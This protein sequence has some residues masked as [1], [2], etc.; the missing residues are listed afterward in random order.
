MVLKC[1]KCGCQLRLKEVGDML[2]FGVELMASCGACG[3]SVRAS[4][5][6]DEIAL[7]AMLIEIKPQPVQ[8][9]N[10]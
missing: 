4:G 5:K 9:A 8:E 6:S 3:Y 1:P 2:S 10:S 7:N